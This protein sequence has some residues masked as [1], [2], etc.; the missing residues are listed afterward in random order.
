[1]IRRWI[2]HRKNLYHL[3][4]SSEELVSKLESIKN[5]I[6]FL[7]NEHIC[8][9]RIDYLISLLSPVDPV[10]IEFERLGKDN[11]GGYIMVPE[12]MSGSVA[13]SLGISD[14]VS[15]DTEMA[16]RGFIVYQYDH[17]IDG[18]SENHK[19]FRFNKIGICGSGKDNQTMTSLENQFSKNGHLENRDIIVKVDIE[20][21]EWDLFSSINIDNLCI[22]S[23]AVIEFHSLEE[24]G[25]DEFFVRAR[26]ALEKLRDR[27]FP[28]HVH[29]NNYVQ[30][31]NIGGRIIPPVLEVTYIRKDLIKTRPCTRIFPTDIDQPN[32]HGFPD[33]FLGKF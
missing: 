24:I 2:K 13:Y 26:C 18:I 9:T 17:T 30:S 7:K 11:D 32:Q 31:K 23:Q 14:D 15:W 25:N 27:F 29:G 5:D 10:G 20:G 1:M 28:V 6:C 8:S 21:S 33:T 3:S 22:I 12:L 19:N 4:S 16:N